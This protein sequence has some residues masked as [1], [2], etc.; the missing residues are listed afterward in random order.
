[1]FEV[2][3]FRVIIKQVFITLTITAVAITIEV[4][5]FTKIIIIT[6]EVIII[7]LGPTIIT[8]TIEQVAIPSVTA[9][10]KVLTTVIITVQDLIQAALMVYG[11]CNGNESEYVSYNYL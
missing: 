5:C 7:F 3:G 2:H 1:M 6:M 9:T 8:I 10:V 4:I 11:K